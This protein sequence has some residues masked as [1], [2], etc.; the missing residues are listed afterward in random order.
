MT[1]ITL[2][3]SLIIIVSKNAHMQSSFQYKLSFGGRGS[4]VFLLCAYGSLF[5]TQ[6]LDVLEVN[7][8]RAHPAGAEVGRCTKQTHF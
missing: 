8:V 4:L 1:I 5:D 6:L 2:W 7:P 3:D